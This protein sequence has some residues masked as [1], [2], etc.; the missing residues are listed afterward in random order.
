MKIILASASPRRRE[1][2]SRLGV[3]F[4]I[5][6]ADVDEQV[7]FTLSPEELVSG[8]ALRKARAVSNILKDRLPSSEDSLVIAADTVVAR[9][10]IVL[11]KPTDK[12]DAKRMLR[13]LSGTAH[14]VL[15]GMA[16]LTD[17]KLLLHTERTEVCFRRLED[18]EIDAYI[19]SGEPMDKAGAYGIQGIGGLFVSSIHG[20][21]YNVV[22]LPIC[23]LGVMLRECG[24]AFDFRSFNTSTKE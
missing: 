3:D 10:G 20:D 16:I 14:E 24:V 12:A 7:D 19:A 23:K 13:M 15:T 8:L 17:R 9:D 2:L 1:L 11:G 4:E 6:A 22:G 18:T 21:Y 5:I